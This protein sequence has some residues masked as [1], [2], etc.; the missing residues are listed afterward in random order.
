[1]YCHICAERSFDGMTIRQIKQMSKQNKISIIA[2]Q[3]SKTQK[4]KIFNKK[5]Q[6]KGE[7]EERYLNI[8]ER[9]RNIALK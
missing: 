9:C 3:N 8:N 1:M 5:T 7:S 2:S 4:Q 6:N